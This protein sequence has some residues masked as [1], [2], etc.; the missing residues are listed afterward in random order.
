MIVREFINDILNKIAPFEFAEEWDNP[1]L[2]AGN[3][4]A[5]INKI[6]VTL[7]AT[8]EAV[9][10]AENFG[11][12]ILLTHHPLIFR[13]IK[14]VEINSE[15]GKTIYEALTRNITIIAVHTNW[16]KAEG[17]VNFTLAKLL[18]LKNISIL[19]NASGF[20]VK[21]VLPE[22]ILLDELLKL[23]KYSWNLNYLD[24]YTPESFDNVKN[25]SRVA[26]CGGSG[27]EFWRVA[28]NSNSDVYITAD[29]KYHELI[30]ATSSNL[31]IIR[32]DHGEME[33]AS[34]IELVKKL[35]D[36]NL[37]AVLL[38]NHALK[39]PVRI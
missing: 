23:V 39:P 13:G 34:L 7:D 14:R 31:I 32:P 28:K 12:N 16:D 37:N 4:N 3:Y 27:A 29:M 35:S 19:D 24:C 26:L 5:K 33:S 20:G 10:E 8:P 30:E 15:P 18:G 2:M 25:I 1:G 38:N 36:N 11:C 9:I 22:K 6:A 17:G 21:G